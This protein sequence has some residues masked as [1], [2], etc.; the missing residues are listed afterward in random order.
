MFAILLIHPFALFLIFFSI[1]CILPIVYRKFRH[2]YEDYDDTLFILCSAIIICSFIPFLAGTLEIS[3]DEYLDVY[4]WNEDYKSIP[5]V[6]NRI[7]FY[8][9]DGKI[10][11]DEYELLKSNIRYYKEKQ[12]TEEVK[13]LLTR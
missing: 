2:L 13:N 8:M 9:Q 11:I 1:C 10:S 7:K 5:E 12:R 6:G 3:S 4:K